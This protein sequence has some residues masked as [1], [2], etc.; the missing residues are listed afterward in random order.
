MEATRSVG[1]ALKQALFALLRCALEC[2]PDLCGLEDLTSSQWESLYEIARQQSVHGLLYQGVS[3]L[4]FAGIPDSL[5]IKL[6]L[7]SGRVEHR[8]RQV[9]AESARLSEALMRQGFHPILMKGPAVAAFY[10][11]PELR[12]SGDLDFYFPAGEFMEV[13]TFFADSGYVVEQTPDG[14]FFCRGDV[15]VDVHRRYFDLH[16]REDVLPEV[17][18][19]EATLLMLSAHILKH[20]MG[21]GVGLRQI[22]DMAMAYR[23]L[24]GVLDKDRL[25]EVYKRTGL[26]K[27]NAILGGYIEA[28]LGIRPVPDGSGDWDVLERIV[29]EGG[30]FG[31]FAHGRDHALRGGTTGRKFD[32]ALRFV[33]KAPFALKYAPR[34]YLIYIRSLLKGNL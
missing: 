6:M 24:D 19:P 4:A 9:E 25:E 29:F 12:V 2:P 5:A 21:P 7:E 32:T 3:K 11:C 22:C 20:A 13:K 8:S 16:V 1:G 27:W 33:K 28:R 10:P 30:N 34:E 18:T 31:H 14:S 26:L 23:A 15:D 17:P